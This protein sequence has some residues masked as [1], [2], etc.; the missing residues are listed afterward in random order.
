MH[1]GS[2]RWGWGVR[3]GTWTL[4]QG[5]QPSVGRALPG[6]E[7]H[8]LAS[9]YSPP[10]GTRDLTLDR[11]L[12]SASLSPPAN[13]WD[14]GAGWHGRAR[15]HVERRWLEPAG[16]EYRVFRSFSWFRSW[17]SSVEV[18][19]RMVQGVVHGRQVNE[20]LLPEQD[21]CHR[22]EDALRASNRGRAAC[23][24]VVGWEDAVC[25]CNRRRSCLW[26]WR[27]DAL[28]VQ[29]GAELPVGWR[30]EDALCATG[31]AACG[32]GEGKMLSTVQQRRSCLWGLEVREDLCA[33]GAEPSGPVQDAQLLGLW[34]AQGV[35][36]QWS[37]VQL[38]GTPESHRLC[39][40]L[41][42]RPEC[43]ISRKTAWGIRLRPLRRSL[44]F[45]KGKKLGTQRTEEESSFPWVSGPR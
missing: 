14:R 37:W 17:K 18:S 2:A 34:G 1:R 28:C 29:Q 12:R 3:E 16:E 13:L 41:H 40:S 21:V 31:G 44:H 24:G 25:V 45:I 5:P 30:G 7:T 26:G 20:V 27:E 32:G 36:S 8:A 11:R 38:P 33:T 6:M 22:V 4:E 15:V 23:G 9:S 42:P 43:E 19:S 10:K 39:L 35:P